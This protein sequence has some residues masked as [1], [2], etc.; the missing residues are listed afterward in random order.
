MWFASAEYM[1]RV[2]NARKYMAERELDYLMVF[3]PEMVTYLTGFYTQG[4]STSFQRP[5]S[6]T[7]RRPA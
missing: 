4:Y 7:T 3:E 6:T 5:S 2:D 1:T